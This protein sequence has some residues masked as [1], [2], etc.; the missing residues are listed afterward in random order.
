M[1]YTIEQLAYLAGLIDGEGCFHI[2]DKVIKP[3][4][5]R[6]LRSNKRGWNKRTNFSTTISVSNTNLEVLNWLKDTF[7]GNV[8]IAKKPGKPNWALKAAWHMPGTQSREII[9]A[10]FPFLIVKKNQAILML[11]ARKII[12]ANTRRMQL[13]EESYQHLFFLATNIKLFNKKDPSALLS[14]LQTEGCPSQLPKI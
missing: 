11:E 1:E 14:P 13:P 6:G 10:I 3:R 2:S 12:D 8:Y 7:G 9:A 5:S 4:K